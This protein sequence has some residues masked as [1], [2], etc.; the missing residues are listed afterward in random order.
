M[1]GVGNDMIGGGVMVAARNTS[2][3]AF[4]DCIFIIRTVIL[5]DRIWFYCIE[6][7]ERDEIMLYVLGFEG[8]GWSKF[9]VVHVV[10]NLRFAK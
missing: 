8:F 2:R 4:D 3:Y 9:L 7:F 1:V 10:Y 6:L 5:K